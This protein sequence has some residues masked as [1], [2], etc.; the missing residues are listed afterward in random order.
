MKASR[1]RG[2]AERGVP[3]RLGSHPRARRHD[4]QVHRRLGD[5]LLRRAGTRPR[6][7]AP[8]GARRRRDRAG[9]GA[10]Q[11][12][13]GA[14]TRCASS[15][16]S[17][18][19]P[20]VVVV[21]TIG[22]D[23]R[24]DFTAIGDAVNVAA[25]PREARA[26]R[27]RSWCPRRCSA[28]CAARVRLRFEGERQLSG[29][30]EPVHVYSVD[31]EGGRR[32]GRGAPRERPERAARPRG[33]R[34]PRCACSERARCGL[35]D[36]PRAGRAPLPRGRPAR[37][38][39]DLA[40]GARRAPPYYP[41]VRRR[42]DAVEQEFRQLVV[43][44]E[45]RAVYYE[46]QGRLA[47]SILNY[48][49]ALKLEPDDHATLE[50]VQELARTLAAQR[51]RGASAALRENLDAGRPGRRARGTCWR[52][53]RSTRSTRS[54]RRLAPARRRAATEQVERLL[55][56]GRRGFTSGDY[57]RARAAPSSAVLA[58]D[59]QQRVGARLPRL[60]RR[61]SAPRSARR[62]AAHGAAPAEPRRGARPTRDPRRGLSPERPGRRAVRR[63]LRGDPLR[64]ARPELRPEHDRGA[65]ATSRR[66]A[67]AS[68]RG[69]GAARDRAGA[70]TSRKSCRTPSTRGGARS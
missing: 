24:S 21:G 52:C 4:R 57:A 67:R 47:E 50:H 6:P 19:T 5:G 59:D 58:L 28:A 1:R 56:R 46:T 64:P 42:I 16:A 33:P 11:R 20:A 12:A 15:S 41:K 13:R 60:H 44:Y 26:A 7:P 8:G 23:R 27:R 14:R 43:R 68:P 31:R 2:A 61:A 45:K 66:C 22:S 54:S 29:R 62:A 53:A 48:R 35:H 38:A 17:A 70:T 37:R 69:G 32:A 51:A 10:A 49:L 65:R 40:R 18:S 25:P 9:P 55:A 63:P 36:A 39:R 3:A 34:S 30:L